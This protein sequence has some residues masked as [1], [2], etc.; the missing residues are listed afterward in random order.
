MR[1]YKKFL[2]R[3]KWHVFSFFFKRRILNF[4]RTKWKKIKSK[5]F[6][7]IR[8]YHTYKKRLISLKFCIFFKNIKFLKKTII[9]DSLFLFRINDTEWGFKFDL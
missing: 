1:G 3:N 5:I 2:F 4:K 9:F 8:Q 6:Y 7:L